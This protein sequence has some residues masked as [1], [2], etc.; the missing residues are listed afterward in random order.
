MAT[1]IRLTRMGSKKRPHYR[2]VVADSRAKRDGDF[3]EILGGYDPR[4]VEETLKVDLERA[5]YWVGQGAE[6]TETARRILR[7]KG[8]FG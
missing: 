4:R 7:G 2:L 1:K 5:K 8:V 3:I 6:A